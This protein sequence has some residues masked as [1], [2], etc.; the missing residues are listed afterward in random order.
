MTKIV[1]VDDNHGPIELY[2]QALRKS[3]FEVEH[4]DTVAA[5]IEQISSAEDFADLYI[6]DIMMPPGDALDL[7]ESTFGL[8]SG[9][10]IYTRLRKKHPHVPVIVLT[11]ISTPEILDSLPVDD[12]HTTRAAKIDVLPFDLVEL[13]RERLGQ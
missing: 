13:V 9:L 11:N 10:I 5:A 2:I 7:R 12:V 4:L 3:G 6:L 1:L 8:T